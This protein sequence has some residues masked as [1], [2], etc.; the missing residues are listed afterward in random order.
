[1]ILIGWIIIWYNIFWEKYSVYFIQRVGNCTMKR[2]S[3]LYGVESRRHQSGWDAEVW[4]K[5]FFK[6]ILYGINSNLGAY[7]DEKMR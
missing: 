3:I 2:Q 5:L 1:M 7:K 6:D 4:V